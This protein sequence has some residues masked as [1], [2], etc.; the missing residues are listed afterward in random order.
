[1]VPEKDRRYRLNQ[2]WRNTSRKYGRK[3]G[4]RHI[5]VE[6]GVGAERLE[7]VPSPPPARLR[8]PSSLRMDC[9]APPTPWRRGD[10]R[11]GSRAPTGQWHRCTDVAEPVLRDPGR[12]ARPRLVGRPLPEVAPPYPRAART[13]RATTWPALRRAP[14][15][16]DPPPLV[17][18]TEQVVGG[19]LD[20]VEEHLVEVEVVPAR[21]RAE[22]S[23]VS[24]GR[25][26]RD[27][28]LVDAAVLGRV[29]FGTHD[30]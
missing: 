22:R 8:E 30:A 17:Q 9:C 18:V 29:G 25:L 23:A 6:N 4:V 21:D 12:R 3:R 5:G 24:P 16:C 2:L 1:M 28:Q 15:G 11:S 10:D 14:A 27:Q 19:D 26:G 7:G 13:G 20:V